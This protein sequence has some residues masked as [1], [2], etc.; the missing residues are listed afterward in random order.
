MTPQPAVLRRIDTPR[1]VVKP[2]R[3]SIHITQLENLLGNINLQE[4]REYSAIKQTPARSTFGS[5][6]LDSTLVNTPFKVLSASTPSSNNRCTA[7]E[8]L[9]NNGTA[10]V[11]FDSTE[12]ARSYDLEAEKHNA[13]QLALKNSLKSRSSSSVTDRSFLNLA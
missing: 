8:S 3:D 9:F 2:K 5:L 6:D 4:N 11:K 1:P 12:Q 13:Y 7:R 10:L